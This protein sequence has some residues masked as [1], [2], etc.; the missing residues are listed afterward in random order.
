MNS[1]KLFLL[2]FSDGKYDK[3]L[4]YRNLSSLESG[5]EDELKSS[6]ICIVHLGFTRPKIKVAENIVPSLTSKLIL[7]SSAK[8]AMPNGYDIK[9]EP[10]GQLKINGESHPCYQV[11]EGL[12]QHSEAKEAVTASSTVDIVH[13]SND[14]NSRDAIISAACTVLEKHG[15]PLNKEEIFARI[16]QDE[17]YHFDMK[18]PVDELERLLI[19]RLKE[20][21]NNGSKELSFGKTK[22]GLFFY[23][24]KQTANVSDWLINVK[25]QS[26]ELI[27]E[28][29]A[30][31]IRSEESYKEHHGSLQSEVLDSV[32]AHRYTG[33]KKEIDLSIPQKLLAI[34]PNSLLDKPL[35]EFNFPARVENVLLQQGFEVLRD[36]KPFQNTEMLKWNAFGRKSIKDFCFRLIDVADRFVNETLRSKEQYKESPD[37]V[38]NELSVEQLSLLDNFKRFI[39]NLNEK[40]RIVLQ[41]RA[42]VFGVVTTLQETA[43]KIGVTRERVRQIQ[44]KKVEEAINKELWPDTLVSKIGQL[45][46]SREEP[47]ILEMLELEDS[48]FKGFLDNYSNLSA[49]IELFS[50]GK[51]QVVKANGINIVG[52]LRQDQWDELTAY[53]RNVLPERA[54]EKQW[55]RKDIEILCQTQ[56]SKIGSPELTELLFKQFA[57]SLRFNGQGDS[58]VLVAFG[59]TIDSAVS[60]VLEQAESPLHF[61]EVTK[62]ASAIMTKPVDERTVQNC[63]K[64]QGAT[65]YG[66]GIYGLAKFNPL[67]ESDSNL[68]CRD[69]SQIMYDGPLMRQWHSKGILAKLKE[70]YQKLPDG[71]DVYVLNLILSRQQSITYLN[72]MVWARADSNQTADARIDMADAFTQILEVNGTP[73]KGSELRAKL[74]EIRGVDKQLQIHPSEKMIQIGRDLW[75][76]IDRDLGASKDENSKALDT[77]E[78]HLEKSQ[79][80]IHLSEVKD[81]MRQANIGNYS[82]PYA[83]FNLAQRDERFYLAKAMLLGLSKWEGDVRR[84]NIT[85]AVKKV[86]SEMQA[87]MTLSEIQS[88]VESLSGLNKKSPITNILSNQKA[89]FNPETKKWFRRKF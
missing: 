76:L 85:Q 42:G 30:C 28:L 53:L 35:K 54:K 50:D 21:K 8:W 22:E 37:G 77:L 68:I 32:D 70:K 47:L 6:N 25:E 16:V 84:L 69:V 26:P 64:S 72:R 33:L 78:R 7:S 81:T 82:P 43:S 51:V 60:T 10:I 66:R 74:S 14:I 48:W 45:L 65:L 1:L 2:T 5:V 34:T 24:D 86:L 63:L 27:S 79:R 11:L 73:M 49:I 4:V 41:H 56:L 58:G 23:L 89:Y 83:L 15:K 17:L 29:L 61:T 62:R 52:R 39:D 31:N 38:N 46:V 40:E 59:N 9:V 18:R 67:S 13:P 71:L 57:D 12:G 55:T 20:G 75:G 87:P 88:K 19:G 3:T 44:K 80:G 36:V